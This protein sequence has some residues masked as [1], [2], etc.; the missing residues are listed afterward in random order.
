MAEHDTSSLDGLLQHLRE[1]RAF[2]FSGYKRT[3]L[4]R[5]V[6]KR[7]QQVGV[8]GYSQYIDYLQVHPEEFEQ[9]FNTIL[10]NVTSFFRDEDTWDAL[11]EQIPLIAERAAGREIRVW[12][13][14]CA[15]G[16]E[17]YSAVM[18]FAE[19]LGVDEVAENLK[20]Y[21]TD[22]DNDALEQAR[23]ATYV[24]R[25]LENVP[26]TYIDKYFESNARGHV[27][28]GEFRRLVI[29][30]RHDLLRDPPISR[31][32]LLFCRNTLMYFNTDV[33]TQ[34]VG[35]LHYS[36]ADDGVLV[37]GKVESLLGQQGLFTVID[38]KQRIFSK[39][40]Q[41]SLRS[42]FL[43]LAAP[44]FVSP[45]G[46]V[47]A[48]LP[49][50]AF[51]HHATAQ[52]LLDAGG[53]LVAAN[54]HARSMFGLASD[55]VGHPF[56]DLE[57]S[58]RPVELRSSIDRVRSERMSLTMREVE[59]WTPSGDVTYLDIT[60]VP[61]EHEGQDAGILL[62]FADTTVHRQMQEELEQTHRELESAYEELQ[63]TN[64]ELQTTNEELQSTIEELETTNEELQSTNEE[65]E[66]MNEELSSTNEEFLSIN[67]ELR[68]RTAEFNQ[69]HTYMES[70]LKSV[71]VSVIV[72]DFGLNVR[73]WNGLSFE[74]WGLRP[75]EVEGKAFLTLDIGFPVELLSGPLRQ[76]LADNHTTEG[77]EVGATTRRGHNVRCRA[78]VS[79]LIG[80]SNTTDGAIILIRELTG[81]TADS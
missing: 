18:L 23:Q 53:L 5:R 73:V 48:N 32:D 13:A 35:R 19:H 37:L 81:G 30:G 39:M 63:S 28:R 27:L 47:D 31:V 43:A 60:I 38:A 55:A 80:Q 29:F 46:Q 56:Q 79:P 64:E 50:M 71:E 45:Y 62:S 20:V 70:V 65:L 40:P 49:E 68:D 77:I 61:L 2:D 21:A 76:A 8:A 17:A 12:S 66:T 69:I 33:Q 72:V 44:S 51:E 59:R 6:D 4:S 75:E 25:D 9:L 16:Q 78:T 41:S 54:S 14:G 3:T 74:M 67:D 58:Y 24:A 10:I 7:M 15:A 26:E 36:L 42:R 22:V 57:V 1:V 34:L 11:R 52:L